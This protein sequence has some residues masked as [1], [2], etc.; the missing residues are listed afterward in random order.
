MKYSKKQTD[1]F[2]GRISWLNHV[3]E[4]G[5]A[6]L[7]LHS[8]D[9]NFYYTGVRCSGYLISNKRKGLCLVTD[10]RYSEIQFLH[11]KGLL[12]VIISENIPDTIRTFLKN[13]SLIL[14][15][16]LSLVLTDL[17]RIFS[18][19]PDAK[20]VNCA[21]LL[22]RTFSRFDPIF[23]ADYKAA[24]KISET[25]YAELLPKIVPGV[26]EKQLADF[27]RLRMIELG[28]DDAAFPIIVAFGKNTAVPHHT[29]GN[30]KFKK[31]IPVLV[32]FGAAVNGVRTD[33]TRMPLHEQVE[34]ELFQETYKLLTTIFKSLHTGI[35]PGVPVAEPDKVY[36]NIIEDMFEHQDFILHSLGH[37]VGYKLHL[38]PKLHYENEDVFFLGDVFTIEPGLY[39]PDR[40]GIR[41]ENNYLVT[42]TGCR[43][44][45]KQL[46]L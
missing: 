35:S 1:T 20:I 10:P 2:A 41:L 17:N 40:F 25:V 46:S 5:K 39:Y 18:I 38:P 28:A 42:E 44:L 45:T 12:T 7:F 16:D 23:E 9:F 6:T 30:D 15:D 36:R 11:L 31:G 22:N 37:G 13:E 3:A 8:E 43:N 29:S 24:L 32:D 33:I 27:M 21:D 19:C 4:T 26:T 34:N 14:V